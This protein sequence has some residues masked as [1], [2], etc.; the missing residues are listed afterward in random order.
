M[1][2]VGRKFR[3]FPAEIE[4]RVKF[5]Q[6]EGVSRKMVLKSGITRP[7]TQD[8]WWLLAKRMIDGHHRASTS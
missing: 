4:Q 2:K 3:Q 8:A 6:A 5:L 1:A 7:M